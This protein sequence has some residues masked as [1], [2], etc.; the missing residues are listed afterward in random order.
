MNSRILLIR[1]SKTAGN[2]RGNYIGVTDE[3][4]CPEGILLLKRKRFPTVEKVYVSPLKR[5][6]ETAEILWPG[7]STE[8]V[9]ELRECNFGDFENKNYKDLD[10]NPDYQA[11]IDSQGTL[12]F[13]NGESQ[14]AF[15]KRCCLGFEL[16]AQDVLQN[17]LKKAAVVCH[18]GTIMSI[19]EAYG[20][21]VRPFYDWQV[22]NGRGFWTELPENW[23]PGERIS[24]LEK[25]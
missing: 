23:K 21:P 17:G 22:P 9:T 8:R 19:L 2:L 14:Q 20:M 24:V 16:I 13:P 25:V 15:R 11:W 6:T 1:H 4:L 10:G 5:C 12:P 3:P 7:I 18:G